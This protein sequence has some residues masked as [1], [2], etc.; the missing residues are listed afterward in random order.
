MIA[1]TPI[2]PSAIWL[3]GADGSNEH[4]LTKPPNE[5]EGDFQ[6]DWSP[7][8][9]WIAFSRSDDPTEGRGGT[10]YRHD[11]WLVRPD[12][13]GLRKLTRHAGA[14]WWP[15]WSPEGRRIAF[16]SD[17]KHSDLMDIYVM[18]ADGGQQTRLT[19]GAIGG[20]SLDWR[21]ASSP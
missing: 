13:T 17:R 4:Q 19:K 10:R 20:L 11:I 18:N 5:D 9:H 2:Y 7:D 1:F 8:G 12:A 21:A 14:N 15:R 16:E 6:P 3:I